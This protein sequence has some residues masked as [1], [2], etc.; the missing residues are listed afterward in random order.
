M[1]KV[2]VNTSKL[3]KII[4]I[5]RSQSSQSSEMFL[6]LFVSTS[7]LPETIDQ[8]DMMFWWDD[9]MTGFP[10]KYY[11]LPILSIRIVNSEYDSGVLLFLVNSK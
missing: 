11:S 9:Y 10:F 2:S 1:K 3:K 8:E 5:Q 6:C 7:S 4:A